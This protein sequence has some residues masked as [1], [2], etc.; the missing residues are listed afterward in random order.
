MLAGARRPDTGEF[1]DTL[2]VMRA[3]ASRPPRAPESSWGRGGTE[4]AGHTVIG[5]VATNARFTKSQITKV[6][7][8]SHDGLAR[9]VR[10]AHTM[11]DGDAL[12]ALSTGT[13]ECDVNV[14]G[15]FAAEAVAEAIVQAVQEATGAAGVPAVRDL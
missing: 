6:A 5:V 8:M 2:A 7:Q 1:A 11:V 14:V 15:A 3:S 12:F 9:A 10:P 4:D 13:L